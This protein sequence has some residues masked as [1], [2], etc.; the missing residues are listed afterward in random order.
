MIVKQWNIFQIHCVSTT[1]RVRMCVCVWVFVCGGSVCVCIRENVCWCVCV[2]EEAR[3]HTWVSFLRNHSG[4]AS[5]VQNLF[6]TWDSS[7][8]LGPELKSFCLLNAGIRNVLVTFQVGSHFRTKLFP[9]LSQR[10]RNHKHSQL[11]LLCW[12]SVVFIYLD[13]YFASCL[14][15]SLPP[16]LPFP[17]SIPHHLPILSFSC[18]VQKESGLPGVP[19]KHGIQS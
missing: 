17:L 18:S 15:F 6:L 9:Q 11:R 13:T 4:F 3:V 8:R 16:S 12:L 2:P 10:L 1:L 19:T 14:Q 5:L 7:I